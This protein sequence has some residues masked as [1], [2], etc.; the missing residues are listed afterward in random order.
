MLRFGPIELTDH[1]IRVHGRPTFQEYEQA[2]TAALLFRRHS[3]NWTGRLFQRMLLQFGDQAWSAINQ[4]D[5]SLDD[6]TRLV[7][8]CDLIPQDNWDPRLS[9]SHHIHAS[10]L[11]AS[12]QQE[13]L[14]LAVTNNMNSGEFA[15][16]ITH[17][18]KGIP[19]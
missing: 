7:G 5:A 14:D 10:R 19:K 16:F 8:V 17:F 3:P 13:A 18:R 12:M 2:L 1:G 9:W 11:P 6:L 4:Y 15:K